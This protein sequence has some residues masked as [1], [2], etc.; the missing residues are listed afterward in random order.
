[1][2]EEARKPAARDHCSVPDRVSC[3]PAS[4]TSRDPCQTDLRDRN[5][6]ALAGGVASRLRQARDQA[7][8]DRIRGFYKHDWYC[9]WAHLLQ[10]A[11]GRSTCS[12]KNIRS[13]RNQF[14][15]IFPIEVRLARAP[16]ILD[17]HIAARDPTQLLQ[18]LLE[19]GYAS[20]TL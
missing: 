19:R 2:E 7:A 1:M 14:W 16:A 18:S 5:G 4:D 10:S 20:L 11:C 9:W 3:G 15:R 13:E 17:P 6:A 8:T 12:Q